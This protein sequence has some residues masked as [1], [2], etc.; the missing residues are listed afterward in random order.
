M[1]VKDIMTKEVIT[2]KPEMAI[3]EVAQT[4]YKNG[5]TGAPVIDEKGKII[6]IITEYDLIHK[7]SKVH[8]P[9][10]IRILD[11]ILYL[12]NPEHTEEDLVKILA[13]E[14]SEIMTREVVTISPESSVEDLATLIK[15]RHIN[16]VPVVRNEK[17][18]GIVSRA[19]IVKILVKEK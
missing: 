1:K 11:S 19:D 12:E 2:L 10:Y 7:E 3:K 16:P 14:A 4:L 8:L 18:V 6:G 15:E 17:L 5:I 13:L 9:S